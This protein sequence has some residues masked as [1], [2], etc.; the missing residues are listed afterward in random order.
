MSFFTEYKDVLCESLSN[1]KNIAILAGSFKP[2]HKGHYEM[3]KHYSEL[4][5]QDGNV[6]VFISKPSPKSERLA[7]NG[8]PISA[9]TAKKIF[10]LYCSDLPNVSF[11]I[12]PISPV[13]SC[14]DFGDRV[15]G[16]EIVLICGCSNKNEDLNRWNR[17]KEYIEKKYPNIYVVDPQ[18]TAVP[19]TL[20][21]GGAVS[22]SDFRNSF[23]DIKKMTTFMPDHLDV[24]TKTKIA[25]MLLG[26]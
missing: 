11:E 13:K 15:N 12:S 21:E 16:E 22:A 14:Y 1:K 17:I 23:G 24:G 4:V 9:E 6:V 5:G 2:P 3:V 20:D 18:T 19:A 26:Q 7:A 25:N 8:K 10:E